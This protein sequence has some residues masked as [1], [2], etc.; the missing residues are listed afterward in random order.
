MKKTIIICSSIMVVAISSLT[1]FLVFLNKTNTA[2]ADGS[3]MMN[4]SLMGMITEDMTFEEFS[5]SFQDGLSD[6]T[7]AEA[8]K[9]FDEIQEAMAVEDTEEM[10]DLM[11]QLNSLNLF[12]DSG[13]YGNFGGRPGDQSGFNI[14]DMVSGSD[15]Q[16]PPG[17]GMPA[18]GNIPQ[19]GGMPGGSGN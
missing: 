17:D 1:V 5:E 4:Q 16:M 6:E 19:G 9:V 18:G 7:L 12:E 14:T 10:R 8:E 3:Q 11:I 2:A 13:G 15:Q